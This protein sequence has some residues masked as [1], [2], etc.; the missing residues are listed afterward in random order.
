METT[1]VSCE[2]AATVMLGIM[3]R[4]CAA[5]RNTARVDLLHDEGTYWISRD[6]VITLEALAQAGNANC[7]V[8][9]SRLVSE[10]RDS[11][12]YVTESSNEATSFRCVACK[13][14]GGQQTFK[15]DERCVAV[16]WDRYTSG[17][18]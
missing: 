12:V 1:E 7:G 18:N 3:G 9:M 13:A 17:W 14:E 4:A 8:I 16:A 5:I 2:I 15:H 6:S 11:L 10:M